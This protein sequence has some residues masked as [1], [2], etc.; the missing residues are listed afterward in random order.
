MVH[1]PPHMGENGSETAR[2]GALGLLQGHR[3]SDPSQQDPD[4]SPLWSAELESRGNAILESFSTQVKVQQ[5]AT[6][7]EQLDNVLKAVAHLASGREW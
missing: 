7:L 6:Q 4:A 2:Y 3:G 5:M 1:S